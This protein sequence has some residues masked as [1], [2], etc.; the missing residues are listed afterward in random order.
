VRNEFI[1]PLAAVL[2]GGCTVGPDYHSPSAPDAKGYTA[3]PLAD[4]TAS[5]DVAGGAAQR[6]VPG[7]DL[8][9]QWWTLFHSQPLNDLIEQ[10]LKANPGLQAAQ[11]ALRVARENALAQAGAYFPNAQASVSLSRNKNATASLAPIAASGNPYYNLYTAQLSV[12]YAPDVFGLNRRTMESLN[13]QTEFQRFELEAAYL[14][15]TSNVVAAAVQEASLR[16]QIEAVGEIVKINREQLDLMGQQ[17]D[18]GEIALAGVKAQEAALAQA[19][20]TLPPLQKQLA[21]QRDLLSALA[22]RPP[23]DEPAQTFRFDALQLPTDL[24]VSLPAQMVAQRPDVRAA[25]AA[26]HSASAQ[27]GVAVAGRLPD[28]VLSANAGTSAVQLGRMFASGDDFWTLAGELTQ[29][30]FDGGTLLQKQRAAEAAYD[31][32]AAQY[33]STVIG[34]FQNVADSLRALQFD[35]DTL[36]ASLRAER[37][38]FDSL[39]IAR[40]QAALGAISTLTLLNA[41][42]T[43]HQARIAL[44]QAQAG[45]YADTAALFQALGGGWWNRSDVVASDPAPAPPSR[46]DSALANPIAPGSAQTH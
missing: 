15:L 33:R 37:S 21:Q 2:L 35:A 39:D 8:P 23:G 40:Q 6:F 31:E 12:S 1:L 13:A 19:E 24:P 4:K 45:R 32:A 5:A 26:L 7:L 27:V 36:K 20:Q 46:P 9:G 17:H 38:S 16:E 41:E 3:E 18:L 28:I 34:A 10:S 29:P 25:E 44:I 11:A 14:T 43:Y 42:Q 30:I 22:G